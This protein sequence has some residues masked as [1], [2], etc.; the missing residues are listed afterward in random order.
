MRGHGPTS[1]GYGEVRAVSHPM[2]V[3]G[4]RRMLLLTPQGVGGARGTTRH[5]TRPR[6]TS[7][8]TFLNILYQRHLT[9][10]GYI[11]SRMCVHSRV[12][13]LLFSTR[14]KVILPKLKQPIPT[15]KSCSRY[16][17]PALRLSSSWSTKCAAQAASLFVRASSRCRITFKSGLLAGYDRPLAQSY[18]L[19]RL[20]TE[21]PQWMPQHQAWAHVHLASR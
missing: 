16:T 17:Y 6:T 9:R 13:S 19:A 21:R 10:R 8:S 11:A 15:K 1:L 4:S 5:V 20:R 7:T 2:G 14:A 18:Q 12:T 3:G